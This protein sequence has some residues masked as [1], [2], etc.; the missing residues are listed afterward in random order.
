MRDL[1]YRQAVAKAEH[2]IALG[3]TDVYLYRDF[4]DF[5]YDNIVRVET[6]SSYRL[7]GPTS[8]YLIAE[9]AGLTFKVSVDF[10]GPEANG[11]GRSQFDADKLREL[12]LKLPPP[13]RAMFA[14]M[15][16][17]E[18]LPPL[19]ERTNEYR[20]A[21]RQQADSE[22]CVRGLIAFAEQESPA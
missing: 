5:P 22:D 8:C 16:A 14:D 20:K 15:L 3:E 13:A 9:D 4:G 7:N 21:M 17:R 10:E 12:A 11:S 6:G 18:V 19:V 2:L 1:T